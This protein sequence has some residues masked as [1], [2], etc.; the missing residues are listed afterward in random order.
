M[1]CEH[2]ITIGQIHRDHKARLLT[3]PPHERLAQHRRVI[4]GQQVLGDGPKGDVEQRDGYKQH[5][6]SVE[7]GG[8][9]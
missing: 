2:V 4:Y 7:D 9:A 5:F 1:G 6:E 8:G 3:E